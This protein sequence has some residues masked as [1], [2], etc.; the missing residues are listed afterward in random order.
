M[1]IQNLISSLNVC[2]VE[3]LHYKG[4]MCL[5]E[6]PRQ[7]PNQMGDVALTNE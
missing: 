1:V 5:L 7:P 3:R 4:S 2:K 6:V